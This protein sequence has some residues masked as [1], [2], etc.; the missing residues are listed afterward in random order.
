MAFGCTYAGARNIERVNMIRNNCG[1]ALDVQSLTGN[2]LAMMEDKTVA[3]GG[4][5]MSGH[6]GRTSGT[7]ICPKRYQYSKQ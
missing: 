2:D 3:I 4:V 1:F 5:S 7:L 6:R